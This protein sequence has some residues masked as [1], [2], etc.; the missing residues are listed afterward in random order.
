[1]EEVEDEGDIPSKLQEEIHWR[2]EEAWMQTR[3]N[4]PGVS[5]TPMRGVELHS[6][7]TGTSTDYP[8]S[9]AQLMDPNRSWESEGVGTG[10]VGAT[11]ADGTDASKREIS[12]GAG[13]TPARG[14]QTNAVLFT[15]NPA[16]DASLAAERD[17]FDAEAYAQ[18][19]AESIFTRATD[20]FNPKRVERIV[21]SVQIGP[22]LTDQ[23]RKIVQELVAEHADIFAL[24]V[25]E[26]FPVTDAVYVLKI[27]TEKK[28]STRVQ[29][30]PLTRPQT[31]YLHEQGEVLERAGVI[32][33]IHP[34][35][36][37]CMS[38]IK[39]A[40][41]EHDGGGLMHEELKHK[42]NDECVRAGLPPVY[43]L[44]PREPKLTDQ[45]APA[46]TPKWRICQNFH[47][48]NEL[49][50]VV[51]FPQGDIRDK[52]RRLSGHR[53]I[54]VFDFASG[55]FALRVDEELQPYIV[56][57]VLGK[58]YYAYMRMPFGL[59]DAPT[60]FGHMCA[61][62]L[63][64]LLVKE[65]MELFVDDGG[66]AANNFEGMMTKLRLIFGRF[67]EEGMSLSATK[68]KLFMTEAVFAGATVGPKGVAP[69]ASKLTAIVRWKQ[70]ETAL[71]L[72]AFLGLTAYFR[73]LIEGY[74]KRE[75]PLR[76][77]LKMVSIPAGAKRPLW[78][79][80]MQ[81]FKL[82]P[83]WQE[84]HT[85]CFVGLKHILLSE[86]VLR[87]PRFDEVH[88]HPFIVTT[89]GSKDAFAGVLSQRMRTVLPG[90]KAA[91]RCH[92]IVFAS[93]CTSPAEE[94]YPLH[95]LEF[96]ALKYSL[97]KFSSIIWGQPVKLETD[98]Q[99]LR[100]IMVNDKLNVT[101]MR[102]RD[103]IMGYQI[104][105]AE[106]IK[107][108][109]NT[110]ADALSRADEGTP[111]EV[112]DGSEWTMS[113]D[114]EAR[115]G[116]VNDLFTVQEAGETYLVMPVPEGTMALRERFKS[117]PLYL[118]VIDAILELDFGASLKD[119]KRT[120][121]RATQYFI[122]EGKLW[123]LG[124]GIG[125]RARSRR[126]CI[127]KEE[128]KVKAA[129]AHTEGG[130]FHH[131]SIKLALMDMYHSPKLDESIVSAKTAHDARG[132]GQRTCTHYW[133]RLFG[134]THSSW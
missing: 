133:N 49:L 56:M 91:V 67:R 62:R 23:Q 40:E 121:H 38:P 8:K 26:V 123:R 35:D 126:E 80:A 71:N 3:A 52:Q 15:E 78:C 9:E 16:N 94:R 27:P 30:R 24:T 103:G 114:W 31:E 66:A 11:R 17:I 25:S 92:P 59:T 110:V 89:D 120:R 10:V 70:P 48:L 105:G 127:T 100:D 51:P 20:P 13:A 130:H 34:R 21:E 87:A 79:A 108:T 116:I 96:A 117:E 7:G 107:G 42:L 90:G 109:T 132:S 64:D 88:E 101:H 37:K 102:W 57:F 53:Y 85:R 98:C 86:P 43:D 39:L 60:E 84:E 2:P 65:I 54:L 63:H 118:Q 112:G 129:E 46:K 29:Q 83:V 58:G 12:V 74:A 124:R 41:K 97:D 131:D 28:F 99:A 14:V 22:D 4:S 95:L 72:H 77:L 32:C 81:A 93:K 36:V 119:R 1:M 68:T 18:V 5:A 128:A 76:D 104:V 122:N 6:H 61:T 33:P 134:A 82:D 73:D 69:D 113:P 125:V 47:E 115:A 75:Q 45:A 19:P 55:F 50:K 111:K 44:P 106:H